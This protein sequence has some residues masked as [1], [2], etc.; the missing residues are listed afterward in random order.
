MCFVVAKDKS[1]ELKL[2]TFWHRKL[3]PLKILIKSVLP[4]RLKLSIG[5]LCK[6]EEKRKQASRLAKLLRHEN[7]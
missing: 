1:L 4:I 5:V 2:L 6:E 7:L 3:V